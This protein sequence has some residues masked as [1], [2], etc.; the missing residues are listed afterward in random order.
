MISTVL[1]A[2]GLFVATNID[3]IIVISLFFARGAGQRHLTAKITA[4]QYLGFAGILAAAVLIALG[5]GA[6]LPVA[7]IPYF[8]LVPLILGL[9]AAWSSWREYRGRG[10]GSG[11]GD[12]A[13]GKGA[14]NAVGVLGVAGVTFAN[15]GDNIGVYVPVFASINHTAIA[16]YCV[17]FV[18]LVGAL[19]SIARYVATRRRIAEILER[20]ESVLFP[21][22][23]I[24]L[25]GIILVSGSA[26]GL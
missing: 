6:F 3:D 2:V 4:G 21:L 11:D 20:G 25:G 10:S 13:T 14:G 16:A 24:T 8:G 7:A 15:G 26:F 22:V 19:V 12:C 9:R 5:A 17:V 23:L 18:I 1:Q